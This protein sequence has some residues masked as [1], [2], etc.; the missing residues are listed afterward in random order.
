MSKKVRIGKS[1]QRFK[2]ATKKRAIRLSFLCKLHAQTSTLWTLCDALNESYPIS[3]RPSGLTSWTFIVTNRKRY[4]VTCD[5]GT[6][7]LSLIGTAFQYRKRYEVTCDS[8]SSSAQFRSVWRFNTASGMRSHVTRQNDGR[9]VGEAVRFNTASGMRSH[10][11]A[12]ANWDKA[13]LSRFQYRKRYE[14]TCDSVSGRPQKQKAQ[15]MVLENLLE[16][17]HAIALF[18]RSL[19]TPRVCNDPAKPYIARLAAIRGKS[20]NLPRFFAS[21]RFS[22]LLYSSMIFHICQ[23]Y[24]RS[25]VAMGR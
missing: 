10:V 9:Q 7:S 18:R 21:R 3:L 22:T 24:L 1:E 4:E 13:F 20:E 19:H 5:A 25:K 12:N 14:V 6:E 11:T 2:A 17:E 16:S 15:I 8:K 23:T